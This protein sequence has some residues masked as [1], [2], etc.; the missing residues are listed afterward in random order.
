MSAKVAAWKSV[1]KTKSG[2]VSTDATE[3]GGAPGRS[4][5]TNPSSISSAVGGGVRG[6]CMTG[7]ST[8]ASVTATAEEEEE[9]VKPAVCE[10]LRR[11]SASCGVSSSW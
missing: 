6:E 3:P 7:K 9:V 1:V 8:C 2:M 10:E 4:R 5:R 11:A